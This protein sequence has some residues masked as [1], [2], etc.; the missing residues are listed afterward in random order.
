MFAG[1]GPEYR[2]LWAAS[3]VS[4]LGD[5]ITLVAGPLLA[6]SLTR[7]PALVGPGSPSLSGSPGCSSRSSVVPWWTGS[8]VAA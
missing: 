4:N 3:A 2:K 6:A 7:D 8:T 5:G 1:L